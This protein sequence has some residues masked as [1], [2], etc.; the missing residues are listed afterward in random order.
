MK[1]NKTENKTS[2][3]S[4]NASNVDT[5][6]TPVPSAHVAI[7]QPPTFQFKPVAH[8][9]ETKE[10]EPKDKEKKGEISQFKFT[11]GAMPPPDEARNSS[12]FQFKL[13][14]DST[15]SNN[16]SSSSSKLPSSTQNKMEGAFQKDFS[17]VNIHQN[18]RQAKGMGALAYT[19]GN[20]VHFAP[21]QYQPNSS[22]GQE[23]IGHELTHVVQ[24]REGRVKPTKQFKKGYAIND[25]R[26]LEKEADDMG[27]KVAQFKFPASGSNSKPEGRSDSLKPFV[28][29]RKEE[30]AAT[31]NP[32]DASSENEEMSNESQE[33]GSNVVDSPANPENAQ[34]ENN[35]HE[36]GEK[37]GEEQNAEKGND[38]LQNPENLEALQSLEPDVAVSGNEEQKESEI[39]AN[40]QEEPKEEAV[41][42]EQQLNQANGLLSNAESTFGTAQSRLSEIES[43]SVTFNK[44]ENEGQA[45]IQRKGGDDNELDWD[46]TNSMVQAQIGLL[47][48]G[49][50]TKIGRVTL[51]AE[52]LPAQVLAAAANAKMQ[53][54]SSLAAQ[55]AETESNT[56]R[57]LGIA[58]AKKD[59]VTLNIETA[60][61]AL[62]TNIQTQTSNS[63]VQL[64]ADF[65]AANLRLDNL[66]VN[67]LALLDTLY[68]NAV[69]EY[70]NVGVTVGGESI[71]QS[72]EIASGHDASARAE[73][74]YSW[75]DGPYKRERF[76]ARAK[77]AR[78]VGAAFNN[79]LIDAANEQA[80]SAL[81]GKQADIQNVQSQINDYRNLILEQ[82]NTN[83]QVLLDIEMQLIAEADLEKDNKIT[84][85]GDILQATTNE[86]QSSNTEIITNLR[87]HARS[88]QA[89]ID[90]NA[91]QTIAAIKETAGGIVNHLID[92]VAQ[93]LARISG[94]D[95][96]EITQFTA[97]I[98]EVTSALDRMVENSIANILEIAT[99][100]ENAVQNIA[101]QAN[102]SLAA[103]GNRGRTD[104]ETQI[105][106]D[107]LI[108]QLTALEESTN[109]LFSNMESSF[110]ETTDTI[111][112]ESA[113]SF[114]TTIQGLE[115]FFIQAADSMTQNF[116]ESVTTM[117]EA[118][119]ASLADPE[120][121]LAATARRLGDEQANKIKPRWKKILAVIIAIVVVVVII[122]VAG[123]AIIAAAGA[124]ATAVGATAGG[125]AATI[126]SG[127]VA[128]A[129]I[130]AIAGPITTVATNLL[131]DRPWS[132]GVV[133]SIWQGALMGGIGGGIGGAISFGIGAGLSNMSAG[134][135]RTALQEGLELGAGVA[136]DYVTSLITGQ[137]FN[138]FES[139]AM[140]VSSALAMRQVNIR[141]DSTRSDYDPNSWSARSAE[142]GANFVRPSGP[143]APTVTP[144]HENAA[145]WGDV[146]SIIG[147]DASNAPLPDGY[148]RYERNG[149]TII[150]RRRGGADDS[151]FVPLTVDENGRIQVK[152][153]ETSSQNANGNND[154]LSRM[155]EG[156]NFNTEREAFYNDAVGEG[157][158]HEVY[159]DKPDGSGYYR[160]DT[161]NPTGIDG[162]GPEI[163]SRKHTQFAEVTETTGIA[164]VRELANKYPPGTTIA[165]VPSNQNNG[166]AGEFLNGQMVLE[167]PVQNASIP[168][169]VID[170]A[171]NLDILIRDTDGRVYNHDNEVGQSGGLEGPGIGSAQYPGNEEDDGIPRLVIPGYND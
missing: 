146:E 94:N 165:D 57:L 13:A 76:E 82:F 162:G 62:K 73:T 147:Q 116:E 41:P 143:E 111:L 24:Q 38:D 126:I 44:P 19:Q 107:G 25:D 101:S 12:P 59:E 26:G 17:N 68:A 152:G 5:A 88:Q 98:Q 77:V 144:A 171:N 99:N 166:L 148:I 135:G 45:P 36:G 40:P 106:N 136:Q 32:Q 50:L 10:E 159:V 91:Q 154:S 79:D 121:G 49:S 72:R 20:D 22:K 48:T 29:Q 155:E 87:S 70:Q 47:Q 139:M 93:F 1:E 125:L 61:T 123:P 127:A 131:M 60:C 115:D 71:T 145:N 122:L 95:L 96:P 8:S 34:E 92:A 158:Y 67:Q 51:L 161:F 63:I 108:P 157:V 16:G 90:A 142:A 2:Q 168:Q 117:M 164:Y 74:D 52:T 102:Q 132:E 130:G 7:V 58:I 15:S 83:E 86:L 113:N 119:R 163:I 133:D 104:T 109:S 84:A 80:S 140:N 11:T 75:L 110:A 39:T 160:V 54:Q 156:N 137:E 9:L 124:F 81:E 35:S 27:R 21:G 170:T 66:E 167:I 120:N 64:V 153:S 169:S 28:L 4:N 55:I 37:K 53:V 69:S 112:T 151:Q 118:F 141:T 103:L 14:S 97:I 18:S 30:N 23:L 105:I 31:E 138:I 3:F 134:L 46:T 114:N 129:A 78:D 43:N 42:E 65:E 56:A 6:N 149:R 89:A 150:S 128:G 33:E 100:G 85:A